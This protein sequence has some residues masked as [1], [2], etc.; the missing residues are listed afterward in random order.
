MALQLQIKKRLRRVID[1]HFLPCTVL[2]RNPLVLVSFDLDFTRARAWFL[3]FFAKSRAESIHVFLQL[4]WEQETENSVKFAADV[5]EIISACPRLKVTVLANSVNEVKNLSGLGLSVVLCNHN[6]FLDERRYPLLNVPKRYDAI[7]IARITPFK[8]HQLAADIK[9]IRLIGGYYYKSDMPYKK[10]ILEGKLAHADY[11]FHVK[12]SRI[13]AEIARARCGLCLS[14]AEG[15]MFASAEYL[16]CGIPVVNTPNIGGR[17]ELFP[18]FAVKTVPPD[19]ASI[20]AAVREF[21]E[22]PPPPEKIRAAVLEKMEVHR[23][24]FRALLNDAM[25]PKS[26]PDS[27]RFPH[28]FLIRVT[29]RPLELLRYGIWYPRPRQ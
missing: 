20:A 1:S 14:A 24:T 12:S 27:R 9:S 16:L 6:A 19:P 11:S 26:F 2:C 25:A 8:R 22:N 21:A 17:D 7:Y 10:E 28:K 3:E 29:K 5:K 15:A 23:K 18:D 4:G 13:P